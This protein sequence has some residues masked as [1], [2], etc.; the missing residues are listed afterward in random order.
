MPMCELP[1]VWIAGVNFNA[2]NVIQ[3]GRGC[4]RVVDNVST[5]DMRMRQFVCETVDVSQSGRE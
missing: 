2:V 5:I 1:S 3:S 4:V